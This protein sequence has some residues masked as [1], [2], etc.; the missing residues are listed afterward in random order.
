M[1]DEIVFPRLH[2][3]RTE[4]GHGFLAGG[5]GIFQPWILV[6]VFVAHLPRAGQSAAR[7]EIARA[8]VDGGDGERRLRA[9]DVLLDA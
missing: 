3:L 4:L 8:P 7:L 6:E 1:N 9:D 2:R 5:L